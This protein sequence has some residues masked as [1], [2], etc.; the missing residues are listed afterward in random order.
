[1]LVKTE[2]IGLSSLMMIQAVDM[3]GKKT[4][5][6]NHRAGDLIFHPSTPPRVAAY[7]H[8]HCGGVFHTVPH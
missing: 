3:N 1:M 4:T 2:R 7:Q 5:A 8:A 6:I